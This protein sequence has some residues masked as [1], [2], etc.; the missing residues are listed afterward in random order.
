M[1]RI[2]DLRDKLME[3]LG[4]NDFEVTK[5]T[6]KNDGKKGYRVVVHG[7]GEDNRRLPVFSEFAGLFVYLVNDRADT[8]WFNGK[9]LGFRTY[10][11]EA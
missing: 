5:F 4:H 11:L 10:E 3:Y 6:M 1:I 9:A 2:N 7:Y 8:H